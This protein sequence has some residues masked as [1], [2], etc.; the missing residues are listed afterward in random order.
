MRYAAITGWGMAVPDRVLTNADLERMVE[1]TDE[2]IVSRTGIKE[3]RVVGPNDSTTSLC[4]RGRPS[5]ARASAASTAEDIDLII[6]GTCTPDQFLVSQACLVQAEIGGNAGAFDLGAACSGFVYALATGSQFVQCRRSTSASSSSAPIRSPASS[7]TP[8]D[9]PAS[10][11]ATA[12]ARSSSSDRPRSAVC[13]RPCSA[14]TAPGTSTSTF[15]AGAASS[16]SAEHLPR[17]PA[18]PADERQRG[19]PVRRPGHGRRGGRRPS[20]RPD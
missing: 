5:G 8:I 15:R 17:I 20:A 14:P 4:G 2:W 19:L 1:T 12:P 3:R 10:S 16:R 18:L 13:S 9:R 7:T 6:V 11:L